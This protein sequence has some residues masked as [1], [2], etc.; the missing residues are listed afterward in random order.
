MTRKSER[1]FLSSACG[2]RVEHGEGQDRLKKVG[3]SSRSRRPGYGD[4]P[5]VGDNRLFDQELPVWVIFCCSFEAPKVGYMHDSGHSLN[6]SS[7]PE[8]GIRGW[9]AE[10]QSSTRCG[11]WPLRI[12][13][14]LA[15]GT[16]RS[17]SMTEHVQNFVAGGVDLI[18]Q[19]NR[20]GPF[21]RVM[22]RNDGFGYGVD[23]FARRDEGGER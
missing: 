9:S 11:L 16:C 21:K 15:N 10:F 7:A 18:E 3:C 17:R 5:P 19:H 4:F 20:P 8:P 1:P 23:T 6:A 13:V 14:S 22:P 2:S 12:S